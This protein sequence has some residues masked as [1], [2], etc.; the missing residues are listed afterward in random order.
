MRKKALFFGVLVIF[1]CLS[2]TSAFEK[3]TK[4]KA[5]NKYDFYHYYEYEELTNFLKDMNKVFPELT[6]LRSLC[7]SDMG[8]DV[9][10]FVINNPKTGAE[11]DKPGFFLN[12]IHSSEVIAAAS[13][14][15]TIWDLLANY[16]KKKEITEAVDNL[17]WYIVPRL[18][19]DGAEAY[20]TGKPAGE[21]PDPRDD[22]H[23]QCSPRH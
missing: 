19:M 11:E 7:K 23:R 18:D 1:L 22:L 8:R 13:C 17:V 21:D 15:Y 3:Q 20:L 14:C 6:E 4:V 10:M 9:W 2:F 12:Q 16:G 5:L